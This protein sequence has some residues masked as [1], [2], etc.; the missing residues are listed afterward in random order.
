MTKL[1]DPNERWS[2]RVGLIEPQRF[3]VTVDGRAIEGWVFLPEDHLP[4]HRLPTVLSIHGGPEWMYGGYFLP[5][6]HVLPAFGYAV[7]AANPTGSTGYGREF[8]EDIRGDWNGRPARELMAVVD[9][10]VAEG[11]SDLELLAVM[12]GSYGGHLAVAMTT[13]NDRFRAAAVDRMYP[14]TE[15]F[16]GATDEKWFPEWEFGGRPFDAD[17]RAIYARNNPFNQVD[18]V[19][20]PTLLSQGLR[21]Y[22][23]PQDGSVGWYSALKSLGVPT[24]LLRFHHEA[25]GIRGRTGQVFYLEQLLAWFERWVLEDGLHE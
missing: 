7:L 9:Y 20:T 5:E 3:E 19:T 6:F 25:H 4:G 16:W 12:G 21:D 22:R 23:C 17:A 2:E 8:M 14:Q 24:R 13:Q 11:W 15:A 10:A 1:F 18:Q